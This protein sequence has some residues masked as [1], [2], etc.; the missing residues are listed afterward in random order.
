MNQ[1]CAGIALTFTQAERLLKVSPS[2]RSLHL[3]DVGEQPFGI[4]VNIIQRFT[5][6]R[7][8]VISGCWFSGCCLCSSCAASQ[9][10][11]VEELSFPTL[12]AKTRSACIPLIL[13][14][15][16]L[17][18]LS[19]NF[20]EDTFPGALVPFQHSTITHWEQWGPEPSAQ[21]YVALAIATKEA[22]PCISVLR[23][24]S[25]TPELVHWA[26]SWAC[27]QE[28]DLTMDTPLSYKFYWEVLSVVAGNALTVLTLRFQ[29]ESFSYSISSS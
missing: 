28:L 4:I 12:Q 8:V 3:R 14:C 17:S 16:A 15:P 2:A 19:I 5:N 22:L 21:R 11:P 23:L 25:V 1:M 29:C 26:G 18:T 10:L 24:G 27:L 6:L 20:T 13:L 7:R 9:T